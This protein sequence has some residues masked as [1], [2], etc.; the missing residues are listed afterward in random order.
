MERI[1]KFF[2]RSG[3]GTKLELIVV[4]LILV[5]AII[6]LSLGGSVK[7]STIQIV[8]SPNPTNVYGETISNVLGYSDNFT[9]W[10][11]GYKSPSASGQIRNSPNALFLNGSFGSYPSATSVGIFKNL[12]VN[13]TAYPIL[14]VNL[15][16]N[17]GIGYGIRFFPPDVVL[18]SVWVLGEEPD[19]IPYSSIQT[20]IY[21]Q[22]RVGGYV[23]A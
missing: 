23:D 10:V 15:S 9:G 14:S 16:L 17:T 13:I 6:T 18:C 5:G 20:E 7:P 12:G 8:H 11:I 22:N 19:T 21:T 4:L 1:T 2:S 3:L